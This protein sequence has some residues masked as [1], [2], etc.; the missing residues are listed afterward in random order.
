MSR[1]KD[2][3]ERSLLTSYKLLLIIH[4][5]AEFEQGKEILINAASGK[6][7]FSLLIIQTGKSQSFKILGDPMLMKSHT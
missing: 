4:Y 6:K 7:Y 3:N 1:I 5:T 2:E